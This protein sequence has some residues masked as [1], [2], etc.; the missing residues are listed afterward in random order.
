MKELSPEA[1]L[2]SFAHLCFLCSFLEEAR[3]QDG[4]GDEA[5]RRGLTWQHNG[6][7]FSIH[8]RG[9]QYRPSSR[10]G[11]GSRSHGNP[12]VIVNGG[13][14]TVSGASRG[15]P[16]VPASSSSA[17]LR[18]I[19]R[20]RQQPSGSDS[21]SAPGR[22]EDVMAGDDP[23]D[24][25]KSSNYYPYYNYYNSYYRPRPRTSTRNGYGTSYH[26]NGITFHF[27]YQICMLIFT[28]SSAKTVTTIHHF[29]FIKIPVCL[30][31]NSKTDLNL[32]SHCYKA[33]QCVERLILFLLH[34]VYTHPVVCMSLPHAHY[35]WCVSFYT[36]N[37]SRPTCKLTLISGPFNFW[38]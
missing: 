33:V 28:S 21:E 23:Y 20:Q 24:P 1:L 7:V 8:S 35:C 31:L 25:Y 10:R 36:C 11:A 6:Q 4:G 16:R 12:V 26:Q 30:I 14:D 32:N 18:A 38:S 15:S 27:W 17:Q 5:L 2:L 34:W 13:N 9:P 19:A 29:N 3:A 37:K 22:R